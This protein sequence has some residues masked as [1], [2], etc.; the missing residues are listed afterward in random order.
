MGI[1]V[2]SPEMA[3]QETNMQEMVVAGPK[4]VEH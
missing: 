1:I 2:A 4:V 3:E